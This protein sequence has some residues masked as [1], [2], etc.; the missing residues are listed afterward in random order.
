MFFDLSSAS[1][2]TSVKLISPDLKMVT[3]Y[4]FVGFELE[5]I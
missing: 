1:A 3:L 2:L 5:Y 4:L